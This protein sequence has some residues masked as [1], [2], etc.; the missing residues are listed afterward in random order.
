MSTTGT[1]WTGKIREAADDLRAL[2]ANIR[3]IVRDALTEH[4]QHQ[5]TKTSKSRI[6]RLRGLSHPQYRLCVGDVRVFYDVTDKAVEVLA[7]IQK[8]DAKGWL[9][10]KGEKA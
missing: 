3:S 8:T 5:P 9:G 7:I 10:A 6:K 1:Q 4:L 2:K